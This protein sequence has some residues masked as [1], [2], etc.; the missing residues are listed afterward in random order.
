MGPTK[1]AVE[2]VAALTG[3]KVSTVSDLLNAGWT[4]VE[5]LNQVRIW[6]G[7]EARFRNSSTTL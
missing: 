2:T 3:L 7:P 4:Y 1:E 6:Q 5:A